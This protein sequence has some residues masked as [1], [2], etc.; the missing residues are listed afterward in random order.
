MCRPHQ[1]TRR[2]YIEPGV[3]G[4][5]GRG[6]VTPTSSDVRWCPRSEARAPSDGSS[7]APRCRGSRR[8]PGPAGR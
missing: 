1:A 5:P 4:N 3:R 8:R 6:C 7:P 2:Y